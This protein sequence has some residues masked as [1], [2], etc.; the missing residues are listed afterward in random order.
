[1][2]TVEEV[3]QERH[4]ADKCDRLKELVVGPGLNPIANGSPSMSD[5]REAAGIGLEL[6]KQV[7]ID[8][9]MI[10]SHSK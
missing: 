4:I 3:H 8:L 7:I 10:A 2:R 5:I 1:M 9:H 6:L